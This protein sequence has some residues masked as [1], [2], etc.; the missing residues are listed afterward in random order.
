M[1]FRK[2]HF[3]GWQVLDDIADNEAL[4]AIGSSLGDLVTD[5]SRRMQAI[6]RPRH[7]D[8][9]LTRSFSYRH[10][11]GAFP[12]HTDTA[13]WS[14][15]ARYIILR[16]IAPSSTTTLVLPKQATDLLFSDSRSNRAVFWLGTNTGTRYAKVRLEEPAVGYR[17]DPNNM[18]AANEDGKWL[19]ERVLQAAASELTHIVW[20][21]RNAL[22]IDNW[23]CLHGRGEVAPHDSNR[24]LLR[25]YVRGRDEE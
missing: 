8:E 18:R 16:S 6:L 13:F 2:L 5:P 15:P 7:S 3:D 19:A 20:T 9:V 21:G 17:F 23:R 25:L 12:L 10:G 11:Y 4:Y 22:V 24:A 14:T 1:N